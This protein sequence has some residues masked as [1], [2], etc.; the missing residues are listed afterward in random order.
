MLPWCGR[1]VAP[2]AAVAGV[3]TSANLPNAPGKKDNPEHRQLPKQ[4]ATTGQ[5]LSR[6]RHSINLAAP[7]AN[8]TAAIDSVAWTMRPV[9]TALGV[10]DPET[11]GP[12]KTI[13]EPPANCALLIRNCATGARA[14]PEGR[15]ADV[16]TCHGSNRRVRKIL[17]ELVDSTTATSR[18]AY[19][20]SRRTDHQRW[21]ISAPMQQ[22]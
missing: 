11:F 1:L 4:A 22:A 8:P 2:A 9:V 13:H 6:I 5:I 14:A 19:A 10:Y 15:Y 7:S 21:R 12:L 3:T 17:G 20:Y 16:C 18:C